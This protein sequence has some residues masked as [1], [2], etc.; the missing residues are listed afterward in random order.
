MGGVDKADMLLSLSHTKCRSK[1]WYY[2][3]TFHLFGLDSSNTWIMYKKIGDTA[4]FVNF[5]D[6]IC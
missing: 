3:I 2:Q 4:P 6:K 1:K 5:L